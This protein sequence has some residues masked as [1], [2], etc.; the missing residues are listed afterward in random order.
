MPVAEQEQPNLMAL[1][2]AWRLECT[3]ALGEQQPLACVQ[4][5]QEKRAQKSFGLR[6]S[7]MASPRRG[8]WAARHGANFGNRRCGHERSPVVSLR[9][10]SSPLCI[11]IPLPA[12][13]VS[14]HLIAIT[15]PCFKLQLM[16]W[17]GMAWQIHCKALSL[18]R[19]HQR[20]D[21]FLPF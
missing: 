9:C 21:C 14:W 10:G 2:V 18:Q 7:R 3:A 6:R 4:Q 1:H 16:A 17:H 12:A 19:Q 20:S 13:D 5:C 15:I 8:A 11:Q